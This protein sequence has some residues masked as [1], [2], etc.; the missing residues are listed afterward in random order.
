[1]TISDPRFYRRTTGTQSPIDLRRRRRRAPRKPLI[2]RWR[3]RI[4]PDVDREAFDQGVGLRMTAFWWNG[5]KWLRGVLLVQRRALFVWVPEGI[6]A[7]R[8]A[9]QFE[10]GHGASYGGASRREG[11]DRIRLEPHIGIVQVLTRDDTYRFA[12]PTVDLGT[13]RYIVDDWHR[14]D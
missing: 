1:M 8:A 4:G 14:Q 2:M 9:Q 3:P 5:Q 10:I 6:L 7:R 11:R 12:V 13:F